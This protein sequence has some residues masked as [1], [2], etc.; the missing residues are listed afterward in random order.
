MLGLKNCLEWLEVK[1]CSKNLYVRNLVMEEILF[2]F[3]FDFFIKILRL[4]RFNLF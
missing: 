4:Y 1:M 3:S 2:N